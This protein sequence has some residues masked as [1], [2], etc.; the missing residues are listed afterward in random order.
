M[1]II[2]GKTFDDKGV[3]HQIGGE[4]YRN[5]HIRLEKKI[6][7]IRVSMGE[8]FW[9]DQNWWNHCFWGERY[10]EIEEKWMTKS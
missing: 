7:L 9:D 1:V 3:F 4:R 8:W 5:D 10:S 6:E 2:C